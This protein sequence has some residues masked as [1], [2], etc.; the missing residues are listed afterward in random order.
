MFR[1]ENIKHLLRNLKKTWKDTKK[2]QS[3][4]NTSLGPLDFKKAMERNSSLKQ[5]TDLQRKAKRQTDK[6]GLPPKPVIH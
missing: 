3:P 6:K 5:E 2:S 4:A 1:N